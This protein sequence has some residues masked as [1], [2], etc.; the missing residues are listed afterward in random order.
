MN[1][2]KF[3]ELLSA[4]LFGLSV[5]ASVVSIHLNFSAFVANVCVVI[6][7]WC[8]LSMS[9]FGRNRLKTAKNI[10]PTAVLQKP[11]GIYSYFFFYSWLIV[12]VVFTFNLVFN[13]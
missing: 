8:F 4:I 11:L 12:T 1:K 2:Q 3:F 5:L 9:W 10:S 7:M 6:S 13:R